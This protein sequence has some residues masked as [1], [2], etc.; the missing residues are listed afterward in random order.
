MKEEIVIDREKVDKLILAIGT[1][2]I[3]LRMLT[4]EKN[5]LLG[6][7]YELLIDKV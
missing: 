2:D 4:E 3:Q 7:V 6:K 5:K 1:V